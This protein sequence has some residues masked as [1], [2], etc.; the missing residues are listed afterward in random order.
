MEPVVNRNV[1]DIIIG[2]PEHSAGIQVSLGVTVDRCK[3]ELS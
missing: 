3:C 2:V 1:C